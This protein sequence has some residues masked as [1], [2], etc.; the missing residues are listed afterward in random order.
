MRLVYFIAFLAA[1]EAK[2][3][4]AAIPCHPCQAASRCHRIPIVDPVDN[5][6]RPVGPAPAADSVRLTMCHAPGGKVICVARI[7]REWLRM[8]GERIPVQFFV[9]VLFTGES[10]RKDTCWDFHAHLSVTSYITEPGDCYAIVSSPGSAS[11]ASSPR[12]VA[13]AG[14]FS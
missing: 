4:R 6:D 1:R 10:E 7:K 5:N 9:R 11:P 8:P 2:P 13:I 3:L 12:S 14:L